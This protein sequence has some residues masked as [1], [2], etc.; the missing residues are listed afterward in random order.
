[1]IRSL[2]TFLKR[3]Q[4]SNAA[5]HTPI[6][7]E[8]WSTVTDYKLPNDSPTNNLLGQIQTQNPIYIA[9]LKSND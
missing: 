1:M 2:S 5:I 6:I 9:E 3:V 8:S 7:S 4:T